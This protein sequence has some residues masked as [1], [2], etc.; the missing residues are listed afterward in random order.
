MM[1]EASNVSMASR[2]AMSSIGFT[3]GSSINLS[4]ENSLT[5]EDLETVLD[6]LINKHMLK[7]KGKRR[8]K[9]QDANSHWRNN[10]T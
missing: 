8:R 5:E 7:G 9:K 1:S 6:K 3:K 2:E 4:D 10:L